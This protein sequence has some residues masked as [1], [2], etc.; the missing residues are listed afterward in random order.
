[1]RL[2]T[3]LYLLFRTSLRGFRASMVTTSAAVLTIAVTLVL[4]GAFALLVGN[5]RGLLDR[6]GANLEVTAYLDRELSQGDIRTL[7]STVATVEGVARVQMV[8]RDEA[9][10][11]FRDGLGAGPL[12]EGLEENPLPAS[13]EI[14]LLPGHRTVEGIEVIE[15]ALTGLPGIDE[16]AQGREWIDGYARALALVRFAAVAFGAVLGFAALLIVGSTIRLALYSREDELEI[17]DLVGGSRIF[18]RVPFLLEG[19][20]Q[21]TLGGLLAVGVLYVAFVLFT[22]QIQY[23]L[24]FFLGNTQPRFFVA[25]EL[26]G[27]VA[28]GAALGVLGSATALFGWRR[29]TS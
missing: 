28:G 20:L 14:A 13:L 11:R 5:M 2:G 23:G 19:T 9:L 22:P 1:M 25:W 3:I 26:L 10:E 18:V 4:L 16:L 15:Q 21:G 6:F 24:S 12:L 8:S 27:L 29:S 17:L 7:A